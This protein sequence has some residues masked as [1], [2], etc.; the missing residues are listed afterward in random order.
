MLGFFKA[1]LG[2]ISYLSQYFTNK[3][4]IDAGKAEKTIQDIQEVER[5]VDQ[6]N[7]ATTVADPERD[8]RLRNRFDRSRNGSV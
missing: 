4:L 3:Q 1:L 5:R 6:A 2:V 8:E 7:D